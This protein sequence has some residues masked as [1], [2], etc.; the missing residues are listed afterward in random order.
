MGSN[1]TGG[2]MYHLWR[3]SDVHLP[4]VADL[5][6]NTNQS[7][8][9]AGGSD[10]FLADQA[11]G[12]GGSIMS[13]ATGQAW[14]ELRSV[15]LNVLGYNELSVNAACDGLRQARKD[16]VDA[17]MVSSDALSKYR[18]DDTNHDPDDAKSNPP[19]QKPGKP[20]MPDLPVN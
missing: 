13:S 11:S 10:A 1:I 15:I 19:D 16:F 9:G 8:S 18:N 4:R 12:P 7:I 6:Y 14:S 20:D 17:D 2:D 5:F 3:V